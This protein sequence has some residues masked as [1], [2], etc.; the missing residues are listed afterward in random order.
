MMKSVVDLQEGGSEVPLMDVQED[1]EE[2]YGKGK[3]RRLIEKKKE[4]KNAKKKRKSEGKASKEVEV[5]DGEEGKNEVEEEEKDDGSDNEPMPTRG[6]SKKKKKKSKTVNKES[7]NEKDDNKKKE[8]KEKVVGREADISEVLQEV[9]GV[10]AKIARMQL[11]SKL[12]DYIREHHLQ[13]PDDKRQILL[14]QPLQKVFK[15]KD[16]TMFNIHKL[17]SDHV[18]YS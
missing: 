5:D 11:V 7:G 9:L 18:S 8:K 14:D 12:W 3:K 16:C 17:L 13:N 4:V 15:V 10:P 2:R 6:K 1:L